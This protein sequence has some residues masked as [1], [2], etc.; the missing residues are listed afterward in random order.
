MELDTPIFKIHMEEEIL[1]IS[2]L[3]QIKNKRKEGF[4]HIRFQDIKHYLCKER[5][6]G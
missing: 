3:I 6:I 1:I 2:K 5:V 4:F